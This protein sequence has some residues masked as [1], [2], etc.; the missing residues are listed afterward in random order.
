MA[1]SPSNGFR[2][3]SLSREAHFHANV[4]PLPS[5]SRLRF[6]RNRIGGT[7]CT[8]GDFSASVGGVLTSTKI[9][10][11]DW[12]EGNYS[13]KDENDASIGLPRGEIL[14]GGPVVCQGYYVPSDKPNAELQKKNETE[15]S[16]IDGVRYF[17]TGDIG[18]FTK[19]GQLQSSIAKDR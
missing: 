6:D 7:I 10:L 4:L 9:I 19:K 12:E 13:T 18:Q 17:H 16:L 15:F 5:A 8:P 11:K 2:I 1:E 14:I 3:R